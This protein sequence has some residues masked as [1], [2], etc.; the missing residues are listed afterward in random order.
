MREAESAQAVTI[1]ISADVLFAVD[2]ATLSPQAVQRVAAVAADVTA[3]AADGPVTVVG[4]TDSD[5]TD[6]DN[7]DL[8]RRRAQAVADVLGPAVGG[9]QLAVEGRGER[10]PVADNGTD[11]GKQRNRR[12]SV[13]FPVE[14]TQ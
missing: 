9:R 5:G 14:P 6:A 1:D 4:H 8:S 11:E 12:V 7:D 3:R 10:E 2:A 13:R